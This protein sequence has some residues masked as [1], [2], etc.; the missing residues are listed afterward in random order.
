MTFVYFGLSNS[1]SHFNAYSLTYGV[2][3]FVRVNASV[4]H[5]SKQVVHDAGQSLCIQ[6][7]MQRT[8]KHCLT[9][10]QTLGRASHVVAVR[11]HPGNHLH[12]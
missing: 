11:D 2:L 3:V 10:V 4:H 1:K 9:G 5:S 7:T 8:N 6:H 12:L